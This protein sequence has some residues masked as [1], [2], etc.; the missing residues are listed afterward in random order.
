MRPRRDPK[1]DPPG[2]ARLLLFHKPYGVLCQFTDSG[3]RPTLAKFIAV[4]GVYAAGRL[5]FDSEGLIILTDSGRLQD[6]I[7]DPRHK[8]PKTYWAQVE[9]VPDAA[10]LRALERGV[11]LSDGPAAP[12]KARVIEEPEVGPRT[13]PIRE[14]RHIPTSWLEITLREGKNR[15]VRRMTAAVGH[16]TLRLIRVRVG[17]WELGKLRPGEWRELRAPAGKAAIR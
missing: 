3:G 16:P 15:Q 14:R 11:A 17:T 13:P 10:A 6:E 12:A 1:P 2:G 5:D 8:M 7:A 9:G 4:R